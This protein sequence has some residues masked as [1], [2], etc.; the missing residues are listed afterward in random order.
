MDSLPW[1]KRQ[2]LIARFKEEDGIDLEELL[3]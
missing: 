3:S 2:E 1:D